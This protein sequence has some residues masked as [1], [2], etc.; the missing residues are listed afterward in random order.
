MHFS[1]SRRINEIRLIMLKLYRLQAANGQPSGLSEE[2]AW[3]VNNQYNSINILM[4]Y[5]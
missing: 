4:K 3:V 2:Q 5:H 1:Q